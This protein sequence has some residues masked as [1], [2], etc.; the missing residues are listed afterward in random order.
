MD[1]GILIAQWSGKTPPGFVPHTILRPVAARSARSDAIDRRPSRRTGPSP[2]RARDA[3]TAGPPV[4]AEGACQRCSYP[5]RAEGDFLCEWCREDR[6]IERAKKRQDAIDP[7]VI[8]ELRRSPTRRITQATST[9]ASRPGARAP[10][11][12][13][14]LPIG[15]RCQTPSRLHSTSGRAPTSSRA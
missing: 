11:P 5:K 8:D 14:R 1:L 3:S 12:S 4:V 9:S 13:P 15:A 10:S 7:A 6:D 2:M